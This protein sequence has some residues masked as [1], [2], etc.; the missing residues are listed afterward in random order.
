M[1]AKE[2]GRLSVLPFSE[3][4]REESAALCGE[5]RRRNAGIRFRYDPR[6]FEGLQYWERGF[7]S[8]VIAGAKIPYGITPDSFK[9]PRNK[10]IFQTLW[11]LEKLNLAGIGL[12][13]VFL[14][15]TGRLE[16]AGG[17][18][19]LS[20]IENMIGVPSAVRSFAPGLLRLNLGAKI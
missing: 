15:E 19:Y 18:N 6:E 7:L 8:S 16:A 13:T 3:M 9:I 1:S 2:Y 5:F 14:R 4:S 20:A 17:E 10:I 12:L 11:E